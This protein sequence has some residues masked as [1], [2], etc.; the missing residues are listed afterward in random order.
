MSNQH[1]NGISLSTI[2]KISGA[3]IA[4]QIGPTFSSGQEPMQYF[5]VHG[6]GSIPA[7]A[8]VLSLFIYLCYS[9]LRLGKNK[10]LTRNE[11][12]FRHYCGKHIGT[13]ISWYTMLLIIAVHALMLSGTGAALEQAYGLPM[14]MG[15]GLMALASMATLLLGLRKIVDIISGIGP[16]IVILTLFIAVTT[17]MSN[18]NN[19][20]TNTKIIPG[21]EIMSITSHWLS[22]A[23]MYVGM[24]ILGLACFITPLGR[25]ISNDK[26]ILFSAI[27]GPLFFCAG[28]VTLCL[29]LVSSIDIVH[30]EMIPTLALA[31][32]VLPL[33]GSIFAIVIFFGIY[34]SATPLLWTVCARFA[35]DKTKKYNI[36]VI[37]LTLVGWFGG[38]ILPFDKLV[39]LLHPTIGVAGVIFIVCALW[40]DSREYF[41]KYKKNKG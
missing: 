35:E 23:V 31:A 17:L 15:S 8:I 41:L 37:T 2:L 33:Y 5:V 19:I 20:T 40:T 21:L 10:G 24:S 11:D 22:S 30:G 6:L 4:F 39:N 36:L 9:F 7:S 27:G 16:I 25:N 1:K 32:N 28:L 13:A 14:N 29:A 12:I 18:H 3:F 38:M 34:T 26:N